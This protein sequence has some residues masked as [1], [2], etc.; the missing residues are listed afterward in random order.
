MGNSKSEIV[1]IDTFTVTP[2]NQ[3]PYYKQL[4]SGEVLLYAEDR[5]TALTLNW[6]TEDIIKKISMKFDRKRF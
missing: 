3:K 6:K 1:G 5:I 4:G 2:L